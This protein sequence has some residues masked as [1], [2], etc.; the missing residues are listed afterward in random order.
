MAASGCIRIV[1]TAGHPVRTSSLAI[2]LAC[3]LTCSAGH[4]AEPPGPSGPGKTG[5]QC[6][7]IEGGSPALAEVDAE[8]RLAFIRNVMRD[9]G[10]RADTWRWAWSGIGV[11]LAAGQYALIP[12]YPP[13]KRVE[14]AF[15]GTA[16]L[17]LPLSLA[18]FPLQ[19]QHYS[20]IIERAS[21]DTEASHSHMMPCLVLDRAE[22]MLIVAAKDE[23]QLTGALMQVATVVLSA[24]YAAIFA[25]GFK[26][27]AG[28]LL[29]GIGAL[30]LG[31]AQFFTTPKGAIR[32][33]ESYRRGDLGSAPA[34]PPSVAWSVAPLGAAPG[35]SLVATF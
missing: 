10:K 29:N 27:L 1:Y 5:T 18:I 2:G 35:I 20:D 21:A 13:D 26:D 4:A 6:E 32:A 28:T 30:V 15:G 12:L 31:E 14:Q 19:I 24:G 17:Y 7:A 3:V 25:F 33:L 11:A 9:Q 34:A 8:T 16:S 23:A 22:E